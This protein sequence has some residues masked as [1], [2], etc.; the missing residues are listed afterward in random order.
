MKNH[1]NSAGIFALILIVLQKKWGFWNVIM[2]IYK[3]NISAVSYIL[4]TVIFFKT[5]NYSWCKNQ[6][7]LGIIF[8]ARK[9]FL[10]K[11]GH[12]IDHLCNN[13]IFLCA[14][15]DWLGTIGSRLL[16]PAQPENT[17]PR[18]TT[19]LF[20]FHLLVFLPPSRTAKVSNRQY[21]FVKSILKSHLMKEPKFWYFWVDGQWCCFLE[22]FHSS[23][24]T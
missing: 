16:N 15:A 12:G 7:T 21:N 4:I 22:T 23:V 24:H 14:V 2:H 1:W 20:F 11:Y 19:Y 5:L 6:K 13:F 3:S 18:S 9:S 10:K 17:S 8:S